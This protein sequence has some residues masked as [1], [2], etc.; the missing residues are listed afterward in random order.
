[1]SFSRP[2][3]WY[4]SQV[5]PIWPNGT[6]NYKSLPENR[7]GHSNPKTPSFKTHGSKNAA[8]SWT[9]TRVSFPVC[10]KCYETSGEFRNNFR[11][12]YLGSK[13]EATQLVGD[14]GML[15]EKNLQDISRAALQQGQ[16]EPRN[17]IARGN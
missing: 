16:L 17:L 2:I 9:A 8:F 11:N 7:R 4:H 12:T 6:F 15:D 3:Q 10:V 5:N 14:E 13:R 1:M